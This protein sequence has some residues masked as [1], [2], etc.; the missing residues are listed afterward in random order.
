LNE[1]REAIPAV[2]A[3]VD[4]APH[5]LPVAARRELRDP[6]VVDIG[7]QDLRGD[8]GPKREIRFLLQ[9]HTELLAVGLVVRA[10]RELDVAAAVVAHAVACADV[11]GL[12]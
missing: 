8:V 4:G 1:G 9:R 11:R 12:S 2:E 10:P 7:G 3:A 5:T 6:V